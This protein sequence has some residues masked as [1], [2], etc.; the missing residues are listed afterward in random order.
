M[1]TASTEKYL[2]FLKDDAHHRHLAGSPLLVLSSSSTTGVSN[3][4]IELHAALEKK[5]GMKTDVVYHHTIRGFSTTLSPHQA[6]AMAMDPSVQ[7]VIKDQKIKFDTITAPR[8]ITPTNSTISTAI[9]ATSIFS[10]KLK[11]T[12]STSSTDSSSVRNDQWGIKSINAPAIAL[13]GARENIWVDADVY[14]LDSGVDHNHPDLNVVES[15]STLSGRVETINLSNAIGAPQLPLQGHG[16]HVAG[17]IAA[18]GGIRTDSGAPSAIGVVPGARIHSVRV[19]D[20]TAEGLL[21]WVFLGLD[22]IGRRNAELTSVTNGNI[23]T[24]T[25]TINQPMLVNVSLGLQNSIPNIV[26]QMDAIIERLAK[27]GVIFVTAAGNHFQDVEYESPAHSPSV[28]T[29][30][31]HNSYGSFSF[32]SNYGPAVDIL[33]PG[34]DI[35]S[36]WPGGVYAMLSGTSQAAPHITGII[37]LYLSQQAT[38][39][40][41]VVSASSSNSTSSSETTTAPTLLVRVLKMLGTIK[42]LPV[43]KCP[44]NTTPLAALLPSDFAFAGGGQ[45]KA[46]ILASHSTKVSTLYVDSTWS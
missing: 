16:T 34:E 4:K 33:A 44:P 22:F 25:S 2:V 7:S 29:V 11:L 46:T 37:A 31:S 40:A 10:D 5:F 43:G 12:S 13:A 17:I 24:D 15:V 3:T 8:I 41:S 38:N 27:A 28:V 45:L 6:K 14:V 18:K 21:S 23:S 35:I 36:T 1:A 26:T 30:G 9:A 42:T 19:L 32:F 39:T 20:E